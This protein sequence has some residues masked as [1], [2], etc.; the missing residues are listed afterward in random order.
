MSKQIVIL[1]AEGCRRSQRVLNYLDEN[2]V[3]YKRI[4]L[5][6]EEGQALMER[7]NLRSSPGLFVDGV[8]VNPFDILEAPS[9]RIKEAVA[10]RIFLGEDDK[11][12]DPQK[13]HG[14]MSEDR[15]A[16]WDPHRFLQR[17]DIQPEQ[18]ALDLGSGPGFWTLSLAE[19]VGP[20]GKVWALDV[21]QEML[22]TLAEQQPPAH[23]VPVLGELPAI[24]L[25]TATVDFI[26]AAFVYHEVEG[27]L[28]AEMWRVARPGGRVAILEWRPD[29]AGQSGPPADHRVWPDQ[30]KVALHY[31][32]FVDVEEA[33]RDDGAY[34]ITARKKE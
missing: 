20:S 2:E 19:L 12:F 10:R 24:D 17:L 28:A 11:R 7:H 8:L 34:L 25:D 1:P 30:V 13:R 31:A 26:W 18:T 3:A 14:L 21:S 6:T 5:E 23:V 27:D 15:R 22:D 32:G 9:C 33:W 16:R 29:T 4:D